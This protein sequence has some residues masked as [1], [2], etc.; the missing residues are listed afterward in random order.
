MLMKIF[1]A[2]L[3][4]RWVYALLL[5]ATMGDAGLQAV[6]S[7]TYIG[8]AH[9]FAEAL[10]TGTLHGAN[11]LGFGIFTMPLFAWF[12]GLH[13]LLFGKW[14]ALA[15][16]LTQGALDAGTCLLTYGIAQTL[17]PR[18]SVP[19]A[20]AAAFNPTQIVL[21]GLILTDTPFVFCVALFLFAAARWLKAPVWQW[22]IIAGIAIA[23]AAMIRALIVPWA[24]FLLVFLF[25]VALIRGHSTRNVVAQLAV[26]ATL[27]AFSIAPVLWRNVSLYGA[28]GL[29]SQSGIHLA[30]WIVPLV[31]EARDG[32]PWPVGH[33]Q[34][35]KE[36]EERFPTESDNPFEQ[37]RRYETLARE[38]LAELGPIAIAKAWLYGAAIN[39]ASPAVTLSPV[40]SGLPRTGFYAT[41]GTS[42][43]NKVFNFL[44][45]SDNAIYAWILILGI[46][47]LAMMRLIQLIGLSALAGEVTNWAILL[48]FFFWV[49]FVLVASGPVASP[50]YR[51]PIE[52]VLMVLAGA[53]IHR[54]SFAHAKRRRAKIDS[55]PLP[56][57]SP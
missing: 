39:L 18:I 38:K 13:A 44:F 48:L 29:T 4:I 47:G 14:A 12:I 6:D 53:G 20:I 52:P 49:C 56:T 21:S 31:Q 3:V 41:P 45:R 43:P 28:W 19:A 9:R 10:E 26:T 25:M 34:M 33:E 2:A 57:A 22:A 37:S 50:K 5:F 32:T 54:L 27:V 30:Y 15:Y 35:R 51:L 36:M 55:G 40:V 11:W 42:F 17:N 23:A 46:V 1:T 16:V 24:A 8:D 7:E